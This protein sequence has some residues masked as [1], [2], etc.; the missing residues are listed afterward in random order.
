VSTR[1]RAT[2]ARRSAVSRSSRPAR[3]DAIALVLARAGSKGVP[4]K[5]AAIIGGK[6]CIEWSILA[7]RA[8]SR[9]ALT[10]VSTDGP[11]LARF[12]SNAGAIVINRPPSLAGDRATVDAAARHAVAAL[13]SMLGEPL[14]P[15]Q[16]IVILYANVPIRPHALIDRAVNTLVERHAD[17]VQSFAPVGKFHPWW[18]A[19]LVP[20]SGRVK[21]WDGPVLNHGIYRR[22]DLPPAF[23]PDGGVIAVTRRAL[24][25]QIPGIPPGPHAFFGKHRHGIVNPQGS[26]V[27]I[28]AP[29]DLLVADALLRQASRGPTP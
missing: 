20:R 22:Q 28:D 4:G 1:K 8:A 2:P 26:V 12:A 19:R 18:T 7:A 14:L 24:M 23:I 9:V 27:D 10:L 17:S 15:R 11:Q 29:I 25:L 21:P 6:P 13:E 3:L 5:N 16:P